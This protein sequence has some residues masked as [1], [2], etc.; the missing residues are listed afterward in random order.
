[1]AKPLFTENK[2][3]KAQASLEHVSNFLKAQGALETLEALNIIVRG[4][5]NIQAIYGSITAEI[6]SLKEYLEITS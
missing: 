6:K 3:L 5:G 2:A 4:H 1:M